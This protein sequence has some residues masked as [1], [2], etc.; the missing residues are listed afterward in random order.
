MSPEDLR[1]L[2]RRLRLT[3][4]QF[5]DCLGVSPALVVSLECGRRRITE[6]HVREIDRIFGDDLRKWQPAQFDRAA[7]RL[8]AASGQRLGRSLTLGDLFSEFADA[9]PVRVLHPTSGPGLPPIFASAPK[10]VSKPVQ[11][12]QPRHGPGLKPGIGSEAGAGG[13]VEQVYM[14]RSRGWVM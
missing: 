3:Q 5:A 4:V 10:F 2:R 14:A 11:V 12:A 8:T 6:R 9:T 1:H 7:A 13:G